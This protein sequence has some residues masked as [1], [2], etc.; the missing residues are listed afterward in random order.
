M[1]RVIRTVVLGGCVAAVALFIGGRAGA[2]P[3]APRLGTIVQPDG[4]AYHVMPW[5]DEHAN[6]IETRAGYSVVR[7]AGGWWYYAEGRNADGSL[8]A[9]SARVGSGAPSGSPKHQ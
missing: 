6:G 1:G 2:A 7:G 5:G 8:K 4:S 3:V 9:S